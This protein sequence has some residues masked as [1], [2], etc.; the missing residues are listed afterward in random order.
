MNSPAS[1][2]TLQAGDAFS[3]T[4]G[5]ITRTDIA[6]YA[7]GSG[8]YNGIHVDIDFAKRAGLPDV[9]VHGMYSMGLLSRLLTRLTP[10]A[11]VL[12]IQSRFQAM[13]AVGSTLRCESRVLSRT[14]TEAG[15]IVELSLTAK[16]PD[17]TEVTSGA[18]KVL[19][20]A[21]SS[22]QQGANP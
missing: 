12:E 4:A 16:L 10:A 9:I 14:T 7:G 19:C 11:R 3:F 17:G 13:V 2:E 20:P 5:P 21:S 1:L 15:E 6:L 18:A 22:G 8:D